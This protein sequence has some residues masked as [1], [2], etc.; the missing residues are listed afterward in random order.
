[1]H[2]YKCD[3]TDPSQITAVADRIREDLGDPTILVNN[4]GVARG[5]SILETT[6]RDLQFTFDVNAFAHFHTTRAFLPAMI[7]RDHGMVVTVASYAAWLTVPNM[8]DYGA[9]KAAAASFHEGLTAELRTRYHAPRV[10]TVLVNQGYTRTALFEG[11][12]NDSPFLV[13]TLEPE[14]VADAVVRQILSGR[15]GQVIIP[16]FGTTLQSLRAMPHWYSY[17]LRA[18]AQNLMANF[19]GRQVVEDLD[20]HYSDREAK[21]KEVEGSTVLVPEEKK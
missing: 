2:Y 8:V 16:K 18:K 11:Y 4:A 19:S 17:S 9:S 1:V 5:R 20:K 6:E 10:R 21:E 15:S 7:Q 12:D 3:L 13:P 14:S